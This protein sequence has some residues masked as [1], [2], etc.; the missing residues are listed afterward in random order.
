MPARA[1]SS[2][3]QVPTIPSRRLRIERTT[4]HTQPLLLHETPAD[5]P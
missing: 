5:A 3:V 4:M 2:L 1:E